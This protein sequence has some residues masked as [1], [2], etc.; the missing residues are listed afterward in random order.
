MP[1]SPSM[2]EEEFREL[3][4]AL[5]RRPDWAKAILRHVRSLPGHMG[6]QAAFLEARSQGMTFR[7]LAE[8]FLVSPEAVRSLG[9]RA[10][11]RA[12][13]REVRERVAAEL[14]HI[15]RVGEHPIQDLGLGTR[16]T[17]ALLNHGIKTIGEVSLMS[18]SDLLKVQQIG[19]KTLKE[20]HDALA[21]CGLWLGGK[22]VSL[23]DHPPAGSGVCGRNRPGRSR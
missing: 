3:F 8:A 4:L 21:Q 1:R 22:R 19:R 12:A 10:D 7:E 6:F 5:R 9:L 20:I 17:H 13:R 16:A 15:D 14:P 2:T 23:P 18:N 11:R